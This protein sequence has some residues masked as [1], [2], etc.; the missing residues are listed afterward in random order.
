MAVVVVYP[1]AVRKCCDECEENGDVVSSSDYAT[2]KASAERKAAKIRSGD[3]TP[4]ARDPSAPPIASDARKSINRG[5]FLQAGKGLG[6][7]QYLRGEYHPV[8]K[9]IYDYSKSVFPDGHAIVD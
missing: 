2:L 4:P 3:C 1:I 6:Y 5:S 9:G 7:P 8:P